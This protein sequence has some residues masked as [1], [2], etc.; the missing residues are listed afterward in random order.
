V[1]VL[2]RHVA[3]RRVADVRDERAR[4]RLAGLAR[5]DLGDVRGERRLV[6]VGAAVGV[7]RAEPVA[8]GVAVALLEQRAR[9]LE[10]PERRVRGVA[11]GVESEEPAHVGAVH[12]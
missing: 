4:A 11:P 6:D 8:V 2:E 3:D 1:A 9:S 7:E 12:P 5:E 10:E